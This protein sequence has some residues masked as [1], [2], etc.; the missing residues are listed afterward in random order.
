MG[1]IRYIL[2]LFILIVVKEDSL[3]SSLEVCLQPNKQ[4]AQFIWKDVPLKKKKSLFGI[5]SR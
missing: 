5:L 3:S 1:I 4:K 2:T